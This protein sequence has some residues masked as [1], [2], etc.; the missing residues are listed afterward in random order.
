M[1]AKESGQISSD[2]RSV[3][4]VSKGCIEV[5]IATAIAIEVET[6]E[7]RLAAVRAVVFDVRATAPIRIL[8]NE[9]IIGS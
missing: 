7:S 8:F 4:A 3:A 9:P 5:A 1:V 2:G 6:Q